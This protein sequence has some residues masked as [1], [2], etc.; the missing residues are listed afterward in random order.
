MNLFVNGEP[1]PHTGQGTIAELLAEFHA[2]PAMT[3]LMINGEVVRRSRWDSVLLA[4]GD[5]VE[6]IVAAAGG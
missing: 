6:L 4:E 3:A 2:A 1:Y 5:E